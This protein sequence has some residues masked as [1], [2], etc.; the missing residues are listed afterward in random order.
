VAKTKG[1]GDALY[2][3]GLQ[4]ERRHSAARQHQR[5]PRAAQLHR[6]R[7]ERLRAAGRS[8]VRADRDDDVLQHGAR[9]RRHA[10]EAVGAAAYGPDPHLLPGYDPRGPGRVPR[11]RS[12]STTTRPRRRRDA[13]LRCQ[14]AVQRLR[15]RVGAAAHGRRAHGHRGDAR[16]GHRHRGVRAASAG[17][18]TCRCS[19]FT[20]TDVD[21]EDPGLGGQRHVRGRRRVRVHADHRRCP[22]AERIAFGRTRRRC[23]ATCGRRRSR[24]AGSRR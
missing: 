7:Q 15:H 4:R 17:R 14:R 23:A 1:L 18:R 13:H 24:R 10:R 19:P 22:L 12:R 20:G 8:A 16:D 5:R 3:A 21:G 11:R 2:V 6:H 9:H